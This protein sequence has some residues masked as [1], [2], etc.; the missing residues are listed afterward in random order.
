MS[1]QDSVFT[2]L[3]EVRKGLTCGRYSQK[4]YEAFEHLSKFVAEYSKRDKEI[5]KTILKL[6]KL[7][8]DAQERIALLYENLQKRLERCQEKGRKGNVTIKYY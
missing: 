7:R 2:S 4:Q 8:Q 5:G 6:E 1:K 3:R